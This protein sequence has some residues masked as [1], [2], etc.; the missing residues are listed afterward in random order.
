[1]ETIGYSTHG[2]VVCTIGN[3]T[4]DSGDAIAPKLCILSLVIQVWGFGFRATMSRG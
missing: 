2:M 4:L 1:M 3:C